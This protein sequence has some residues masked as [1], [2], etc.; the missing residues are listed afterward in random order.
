MIR[1]IVLAV[2]L[3]A[4]SSVQA[5]GPET[6]YI[7]QSISFED[8]RSIDPKVLRCTELGIRFSE[9]LEK[10]GTKYKFNVMR[11]NEELEGK[12]NYLDTRITSAVSAGNAWSGHMKYASASA[13]IYVG[14][15]EVGRTDVRRNSR[16]GFAGGF[17]GSCSILNRTVNALASD[18]FKWLSKN[19][20]DPK[21]V[22]T[23]AVETAEVVIDNTGD[24]SVNVDAEI[25]SD[26][27]VDLYDELMKLDE[28]RQKGILTEEEFASQKALLLQNSQ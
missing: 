21:A 12:D 9:Y 3:V 17:K 6:L 10:H 22:A 7:S 18:I 5:A 28:L 27:P 16:G 20:S 8:E 2:V 15:V 14:G 26:A 11:T 13:I 23:E 1:P 25:S 24:S 4:T 19:H